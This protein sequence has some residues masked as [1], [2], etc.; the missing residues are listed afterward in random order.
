MNVDGFTMALWTTDVY[1]R[2]A[3]PTA[4][5]DR[6]DG[7]FRYLVLL[8]SLPVL[9]L[10]GFPLLEHAWGDFA[11]GHLDR[12]AA[13]PG[14]GAAFATSFLS[15]LRGEGPIYFEV[16]CVILV[17]TTLGRWLEATGRSRPFRAGRWCD[18]LPDRVAGLVDGEEKRCRDDLS[19]AMP[20][21]CTGR[22][23]PRRRHGYAI[24]ALV[25]E[26]V[27]T[28]ESRPVLK[29][30]G[31]RILGG[32]LNLDGDLTIEVTEARGDET[33]RHASWSWSAGPGVEG[34]Y[35]RLVDRVA[36]LFVPTVAAIA[37]SA[38]GHSACGS[39]EH[40]LGRGWRSA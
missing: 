10:L 38:L 28:G 12:L 1:G 15:V 16:G 3:G 29:E 13:G 37:V 14:V 11:G 30:P 9:L 17:M 31:D 32:T 2:T 39:L 23:V 27:L 22:T 24:A 4:C 20:S 33:A 6:Y 40:G 8:F 26:Q 21:G 36:G 34:R 7:L 5:S 35:Q 25:D 19:R 18:C